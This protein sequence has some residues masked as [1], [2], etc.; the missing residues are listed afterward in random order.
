MRLLTATVLSQNAS[1]PLRRRLVTSWLKFN[2]LC[3]CYLEDACG[4]AEPFK[5]ERN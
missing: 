2:K 1:S 4:E 3:K 5:G